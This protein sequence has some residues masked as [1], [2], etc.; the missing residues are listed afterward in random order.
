[1]GNSRIEMPA[2]CVPER[3]DQAKSPQGSAFI[4]QSRLHPAWMCAA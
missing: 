1:M 3:A 2:M 4:W